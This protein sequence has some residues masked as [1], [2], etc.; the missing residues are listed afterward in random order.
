MRT[1]CPC[2][3]IFILQ[4]PRFELHLF[5]KLKIRVVLENWYSSYDKIA[6]SM[7]LKTAPVFIVA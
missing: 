7:L 5:E 1:A 2:I 6:V 4:K 3:Y